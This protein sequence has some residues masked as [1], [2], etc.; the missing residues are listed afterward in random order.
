[1]YTVRHR[2]H[3]ISLGGPYS[4]LRAWKSGEG[5]FFKPHQDT[6]RANDMFGT[7]VVV[8]PAPHE[9]GALVLRHDGK[10]W[11]FDANELLG[12]R[13][14]AIAYVAFFSDVE[15]EVL[16][17]RSGNRVTLTYN[18]YY[19]PRTEDAVAFPP[20]LAARVPP[21]AS[22]IAVRD[23]LQA[24]LDDESFLPEGGTLGFGLRH[25]Y[26]FPKIWESGCAYTKREADP[27]PL[28]CLREWLKGGDDAL[29]SACRDLGLKPY[30]RVLFNGDEQDVLL[31]R[32]VDFDDWARDCYVE[33]ALLDE[34]KH[35]QL[36]ASNYFGV[37]PKQYDSYE[38]P[39]RGERH[40]R[41]LTVHWITQA[42]RWNGLAAHYVA[43]GNEASLQHLYASVCLLVEIGCS[44]QRV[45]NEIDVN[46]G[47]EPPV[48]DSSSDAE[49]VDDE[50]NSE[51]TAGA[52]D[53]DGEDED[54]GSNDSR[55]S[56]S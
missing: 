26:P 53:S 28:V 40:S 1:M 22:V 6:P 49:K 43:M 20:G 14:D 23:A 52:E 30:L 11:T 16:P 7:L 8:F 54:S 41:T 31:D 38:R 35:A 29:L 45:P 55:V 34:H 21:H 39:R 42:E 36:L 37:E 5:A 24:L 12:G 2:V 27:N 17:V 56:G 10:E 9:G 47:G 48:V 19:G 46:N 33:T 32:M 50:T 4:L 18:L 51:E 13:A 15:H 44:G 3:L 25:R